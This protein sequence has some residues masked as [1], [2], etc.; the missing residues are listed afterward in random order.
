MDF[1][2]VV[3]DELISSAR[4]MREGVDN[5]LL[6]M[7]LFAGDRLSCC[8]EGV[9]AIGQDGQILGLVT[10]AP[11]G[12]MMEG[13]PTIVAVAVSSHTRRQG[14]AKQLFVKA[15]QRMQERGLSLPYRVDTITKMGKGLVASLGDDTKVCLQV[16]DASKYSLS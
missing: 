16:V 7:V 11:L 1:K 2:I 12:E 15:V 3:N 10:I 6:A 9:A 4:H 13:C 5:P 8:D 14:I